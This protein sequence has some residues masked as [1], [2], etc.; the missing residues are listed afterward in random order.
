MRRLGSDKWGPTVMLPQLLR[1][2]AR[3]YLFLTENAVEL[4][5]YPAD[6][7]SQARAFYTRTGMI[8]AVLALAQQPGWE[9]KPNFHFGHMEDGYTW[10]TTS[11]DVG[12]YVELW[13]ETIADTRAIK[14]YQWDEYWAWLL[15][16]SIA[17]A[18]DRE[19]FDRHFTA[20]NRQSA[21]PRP[22]LML[23]RSWERQEAETLDGA[24]KL[25]PAIAAAFT[26]AVQALAP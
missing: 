24:H 18:K 7:L 19:D 13:R 17:E 4:S 23:V 20:T 10:T 26:Q 21:I 9:L 11:I 25:A 14:R 8:E 16:Q 1:T 12:S 5:V 6:T 22:G 2:A 15:E 3:A